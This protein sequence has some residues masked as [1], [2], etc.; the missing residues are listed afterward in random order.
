MSSLQDAGTRT[1]VY[2]THLLRPLLP[3]TRQGQERNR[4]QSLP[5]ARL[6]RRVGAPGPERQNPRPRRSGV[7]RAALAPPWARGCGARH[8]QGPRPASP[9]RC[10][11]QPHQ[12]ERCLATMVASRVLRSRPRSLRP[13]AHPRCRQCDLHPGRRTRPRSG[14]Q[15]EDLYEAMDWLGERQARI[16][17]ALAKRHLHNG[18]LVL[19]DVSSS[20]LEG[21]RCALGR[22]GYSRDGKKG[23]LQIVYGLLCNAEGLPKSPSKSTKAT[24]PTRAPWPTRSARCANA[25]D[26]NAWCSSATGGMLTSAR[27]DEELRPVEGPGLD[28][29]VAQRCHR[30]ARRQPRP[31]AALIV[32]CHR[33]S[34]DPASGLPRR[35]PHR[36]SQSAAARGAGRTNARHCC[37]P[38]RRSS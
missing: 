27:I 32:R 1:R 37:A 15:A 17:R 34:R 28:Q 18:T 33:P 35:T 36:L 5:S 25:S 22:I 30:P 10:S 13:C 3:R 38:P 31:F 8:H 24:P 12:R 29:C 26:S 21:R 4:R 9:A 19:Y 2:T 20:Y 14:V 7:A 16:E 11:A 23:K 6:G